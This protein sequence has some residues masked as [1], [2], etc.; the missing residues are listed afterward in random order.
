MKIGLATINDQQHEWV[1]RF[2][3]AVE[4]DTNHEINVEIYPASQL[5]S[6][7]RMIEQTQFGA[8][9]AYAG[10]A[11]FFSGVDPRYSVLGAPL[12]FESPQQAQRT[13]EDPEVSRSFLGLGEP[14]GLKG[15]ALFFYGFNGIDSRKDIRSVSELGGLKVRDYGGPL[16][17]AQLRAL[18][19][20]AV[21][22]PLDQVL[23]ALQQGAVDGTVTV[24]GTAQALKYSGSARYYV[25]LNLSTLASVVV[26]SKQWYDR[27]PANLQ[28]VISHDGRRVSHDLLPY[29]LD[30]I[31]RQ[32][33]AWVSGGGVITALS[34]AQLQELRAR[35]A[36]VIDSALRDAPDVK[37][38]YEAVARVAQ[39]HRI[40]SAR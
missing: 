5:G 30:F 3:E 15:I 11:D 12:L 28:R 17:S 39:R 32:S 8:I 6:I 22:M 9:Q 19:I 7:P 36:G 29:T 2:K 33:D 35:Q 20:T 4:R 21:P 34:P 26:V 18:G 10:P 27:L 24:I 38:Y 23:P 1:K 37:R 40:A 25:P 31:K 14:K 16:Q 13:F